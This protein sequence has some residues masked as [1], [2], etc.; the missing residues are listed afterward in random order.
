MQKTLTV[1]H[2]GAHQATDDQIKAALKKEGITG[3]EEYKFISY[4]NRSGKDTKMT[5]DVKVKSSAT[6]K[7]EDEEVP[8]EEAT[9][10]QQGGDQEVGDESGSDTSTGAGS[11]SGR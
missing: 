7:P 6:P 5:L 1:E 9:D 8:D 4:T 11:G 3:V 2:P 10:D